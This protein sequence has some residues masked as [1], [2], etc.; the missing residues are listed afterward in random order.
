[1]TAG[2]KLKDVTIFSRLP[3]QALNSIVAALQ[4]RQLTAG[5]V[6][7]NQGDPGDELIIVESGSIAIFAPSEGKSSEGQAIRIFKSG[8]ML[9][10][11]ALIHQKPR[12]L[13]ARAE[14]NSTILTLNGS[15]FRKLLAENPDMSLAVMAGLNDRIRY[16]TDFLSE[17]SEWVGKM[18]DGNY[19]E[20][21]KP[22]GSQ[23]KDPTL[24]SLASEFARMAVQVKARED[25][26]RQ[27]VAHLRI[28]VNE[29]K[30]KQEVSEI[31][32]SDYYKDLREKIK[33]LR[34]QNREDN[35]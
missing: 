9:G 17:V 19:Q 29:A 22:Q 8:G 27:E 18:A 6:I 5:Q 21:A 30:R 11:M 15:E 33:N 24:A 1:M 34:A 20:A 13:S 32:G 14:E 12:S 2:T 35:S 3:N 31:M 4:P 25:Q 23:Y 7:F 26:L 16:T 10:E 28:E